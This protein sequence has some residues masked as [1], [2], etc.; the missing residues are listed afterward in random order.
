MRKEV[1][2]GM[3]V[4]FPS[5]GK[6]LKNGTTY[7]NTTIVGKFDKEEDWQE[8]DKSEYEVYQKSLMKQD[9]DVADV[10]PGE[11]PA[12]PDQPTA[13][14]MAKAR[15]IGEITSWDASSAVNSFFIGGQ[16]MWL[17]F[18]ERE[19]IRSSISAYK[20]LGKTEMTKWFSGVKFSFQLE[21]WQMMIDALSVYAS[22]CLN[23][24]EEHKANVQALTSIDDVESY[25]FKQNYPQ[26]IEL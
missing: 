14:E 24:T 8:V 2:N 9:G 5:S 3:C 21:M 23:V 17:T 13:L 19:R 7:A 22:E 18:D 15:K 10:K 26:K 4:L 6:M 11:Q 16:R 25:D 1:I 20:N 12:I